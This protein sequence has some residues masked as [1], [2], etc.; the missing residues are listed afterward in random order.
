MQ[1]C[2]PYLMF[3]GRADE[4]MREYQ[5]VLGGQLNVLRYSD[6]PPQAA[7]HRSDASRSISSGSCTPC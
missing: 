3:D 4:A 1:S 7:R 5:R 6:A 2:C